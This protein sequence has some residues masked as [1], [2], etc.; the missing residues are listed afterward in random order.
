M[1]PIIEHLIMT[2]G[3]AAIF[4]GAALE[5]EA[6]VTAGG[7]LAHRHLIEPT[8]AA[9]CAF[10]GSFVMDQIVFA[11]GRLQRRRSYVQRVRQ[12]PRFDQAL[13]FIERRP[14]IFCI[15]FRFIYGFRIIG[16]LAIGVS[17]IP[18]RQF[19]V[20]NAVSAA[21]WASTFTFIG[22][23]FGGAFEAALWRIL[24]SWGTVIAA[25]LAGLALGAALLWWRRR[26]HQSTS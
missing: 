10:A 7:F 17:L 25:A 1:L 6:A 26:N 15:V 9:L 8:L 11:A 4:L 13:R 16:P 18:A 5:R 23:H 24:G 20:L 3:G 19:F 22:Y 2:Y 21:V 14:V 12:K